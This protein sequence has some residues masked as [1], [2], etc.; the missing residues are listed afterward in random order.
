TLAPSSTIT[1]ATLTINSIYNWDTTENMLFIHLLDTA[2]NAG[3]ASFQDAP[4][5]QAPV[6][7]ITDD[8]ANT[9]YHSSSK[10]LVANGTADTFLAQSSSAGPGHAV[11]YTLNFTAAE[12]LVLSQ[13]I[14]NGRN[15]AFGFDPDCHFFDNGIVFTITT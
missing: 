9:R 8:F 11:T 1:G 14:A 5:N 7:D 2:K 6:D 10:W 15:I 4:K 12:L 3:V 13:Y